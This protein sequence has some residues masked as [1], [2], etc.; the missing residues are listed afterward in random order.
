MGVKLG[1]GRVARGRRALNAEINVTP[2]VDVMLV[3]LIVF[4]ISA[5][6][7]VRGEEVNLPKTQSGQLAAGTDQPLTITVTMDGGIFLN[8]GNEVTLEELGPRLVAITGE[9]YEELIYIRA[10]EDATH[11]DVMAVTSAV[12]GTGFNRIA[13]VTDPTSAR[14][15]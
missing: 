11:G 13:Y 2:F 15:R 10:D 5:P 9:G 1:T 6:L 14:G 3:L 8:E 4:I 7:L 12:S